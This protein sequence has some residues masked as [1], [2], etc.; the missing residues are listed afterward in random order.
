MSEKIGV[1]PLNRRVGSIIASAQISVEYRTG[2]RGN[3]PNM[4]RLASLICE[5]SPLQIEVGYANLVARRLK[6]AL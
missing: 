1:T 4:V 5:G 6:A 2:A 3:S